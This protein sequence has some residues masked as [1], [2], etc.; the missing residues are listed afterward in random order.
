M[1]YQISSNYKL[2]QKNSLQNDFKRFFDIKMDIFR[3]QFCHFLDIIWIKTEF[4]N[5]TTSDICMVWQAIALLKNLFIKTL[6]FNIMKKITLKIFALLLMACA[7]T[8][9]MAQAIDITPAKF[10]FAS[11]PVGKFVY[12]GV[13]TKSYETNAP[14]KMQ[15]AISAD[16]GYSYLMGWGNFFAVNGVDKGNTSYMREM[17]NIIDLGGEVGKVLCF[18]GHACSDD[19]FAYGIKPDAS[20]LTGDLE[21]PSIAFYLGNTIKGEAFAKQDYKARVSITWRLAIPEEE[22]SDETDAFTFRINDFSINTKPF[23]GI[24]DQ[25]SALS[26]ETEMADTW[27]TQEADF[28]FYGDEEQIPL[29]IKFSFG[30]YTT[31][32]ALLI[33]ELK[34]TLNPEGEPVTLKH[35]TLMMN[36]TSITEVTEGEKHD[37]HIDGNCIVMNNIAGENVALYNIQGAY[38]KAIKA[39]QSTETLIV[40]KKGVYVLQIGN[41]NYKVIL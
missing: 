6:N 8:T 39:T 7:T 12:D 34:V 19:V 3:I 28:N 23:V 5:E 26:Y 24:G 13:P 29:L 16:G 1:K 9:L 14:A 40:D 35:Q 20:L 4:N 36:P 17:S 18:K 21:W 27:C 10:K 15:S 30:K 31:M 37:F 25:I 2:T 22:Y 11:Q 33:K 41:K 32:G 38:V